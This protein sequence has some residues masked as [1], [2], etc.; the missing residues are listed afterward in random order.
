MVAPAF[1]VAHCLSISF[2]RQSLP[3]RKSSSP[4]A[5]QVSGQIEMRPAENYEFPYPTRPFL[6]AWSQHPIVVVQDKPDLYPL[7]LIPLL[8][9]ALH[10]GQYRPLYYH[11]EAGDGIPGFGLFRLLL[12][13]Y[14]TKL[15][16]K[17]YD[18]I[19]FRILNGVGENCSAFCFRALC[20][21][22]IKSWP[23]KMLSPNIRAQESPPMNSLPGDKGLCQTRWMR[24]YR[25]IK[26]DTPLFSISQQLLEYW[27]I[28]RCWNYQDVLSFSV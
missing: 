6:A 8:R 23:W 12:K 21:C 28:S 20:S 16:V 27:G 25:I 9:K 17:L 10:D 18:P 5:A 14:G 2:S 1:E 7:S 13:A 4:A 19:P 24:L 11:I 3:D 26:T 22:F 15:I